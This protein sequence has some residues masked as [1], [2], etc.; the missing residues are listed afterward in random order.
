MITE[1]NIFSMLGL[2]F[3][4]PRKVT[5]VSRCGRAKVST[6]VPTC[7]RYSP[8]LD[9]NTVMP[10]GRFC[11]VLYS[12][13]WTD[14]NSKL[15]LKTYML[16]LRIFNISFCASVF[17]KNDIHSVGGKENRSTVLLGLV[18]SSP[19]TYAK[20]VRLPIYLFI[21]YSIY[22]W[23]GDQWRIKYFRNGTMVWK[24]VNPA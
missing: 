11:R 10:T 20:I 7:K 14:T 24:L 16:N 22:Y 18:C 15:V 23:S 4:K 12:H 2:L 3:A 9:R 5:I 13:S 6:Y 1:S 21:Y 17:F 19:H 8:Q